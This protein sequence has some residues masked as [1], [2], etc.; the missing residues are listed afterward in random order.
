MSAVS[1]CVQNYGQSTASQVPAVQCWWWLAVMTSHMCAVDTVWEMVLYL[2]H[3]RETAKCKKRL[4]MPLS[5]YG[6]ATGTHVLVSTRNKNCVGCFN[7]QV[8]LLQS[9]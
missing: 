5:A 1:G 4:V 9:N 7:V 8:V 2:Q 3:S 6:F